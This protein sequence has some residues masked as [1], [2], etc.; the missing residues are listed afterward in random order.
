MVIALSGVITADAADTFPVKIRVED[1]SGASV[2]DELVIIQDLNNREHEVNRAL[3]KEDG[4][5][6]PFQLQPGLYR[7]IATAPYGLWETNVRE[8]LV[9]QKP[10][11]VM[12]EVRPLGTHGYGDIVPM[13]AIRRQLHVIGSDGLPVSGANILLRDRDATL[14]LERWYRTDKNGAAQIELVSDPTVVVVVYGDDLLTTELTQHV[15]N[16][17]IRLQ[18]R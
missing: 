17:V 15:V 7:V 1:A 9:S 14:H 16:P 3:S 10:T 12:V 5:V 11:E 13:R 6:P 18:R 2:K 4:T 8:F